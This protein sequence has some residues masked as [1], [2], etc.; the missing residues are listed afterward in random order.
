MGK[1][2]P[3]MYFI[4]SLTVTSGSSI[5]VDDGVDHFAQVVRGDVGR[6]P[7]RDARRAVDHEV[8]KARWQVSGCSSESS[9]LGT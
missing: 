6:H 5:I 7:D 4:K 8:G 9:K 1:S 2:G 3:L